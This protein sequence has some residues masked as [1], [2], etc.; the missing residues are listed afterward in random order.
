MQLCPTVTVAI[1]NRFLDELPKQTIDP[2]I[3]WDGYRRIVCTICCA[4]QWPSIDISHNLLWPAMAINRHLA[5]SIVAGNDPRQTYPIIYCGQQWTSVGISH[6][7]LWPA[8]AIDK[9]LAQSTQFIGADNTYRFIP[10]TTH[11]RR[12]YTSIGSPPR[13]LLKQQTIVGSIVHGVVDH[14]LISCRGYTIRTD[15]TLCH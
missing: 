5:Q 15:D 4:R 9:H 13:L 6:N 8:T 1:R 2:R 10:S 12:Q 11:C 7:L 3:S 14:T